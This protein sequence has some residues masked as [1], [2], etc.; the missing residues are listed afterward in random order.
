M[1]VDPVTSN[2]RL[3][4]APSGAECSPRS[5]SSDS[6]ASGPVRPDID[7]IESIDVIDSIAANLQVSFCNF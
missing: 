2:L 6:A 7:V 4:P 1:F 3:R 5:V